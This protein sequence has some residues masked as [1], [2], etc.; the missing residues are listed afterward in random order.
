MQEGRDRV[1]RSFNNCIAT[2]EK[3]CRFIMNE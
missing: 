2:F 1:A 3:P